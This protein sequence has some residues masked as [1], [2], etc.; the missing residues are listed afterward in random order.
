MQSDI[1]Y[2]LELRELVGGSTAEDLIRDAEAAQLSV[3]ESVEE[4]DVEDPDGEKPGA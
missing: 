2:E 3:E 1:W 4:L